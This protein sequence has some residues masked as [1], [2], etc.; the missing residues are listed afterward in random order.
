MQSL[1]ALF[2]RIHIDKLHTEDHQSLVKEPCEQSCFL[3]DG[4]IQCS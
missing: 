1:L 4:V 2:S 3:S